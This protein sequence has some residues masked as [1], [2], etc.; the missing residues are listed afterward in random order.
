M[1]QLGRVLVCGAGNMAQGIFEGLHT[2]IDLSHYFFYTPSGHRAQELAKRVGA[3]WLK[4]LSG[5]GGFDWIFLA[6]KPQQLKDLAPHVKA[7]FPHTPVVSFLAALSEA[8][9]RQVLGAEKLIRLMPNLASRYHQGIALLCSESAPEKLPLV[10]E[11][12]S[13]LGYTQVVKENELDELTL[14]T[15]SGPAIFYELTHILAQSFHS[16]TPEV[17]Q[18][19]A[20]RTLQGAACITQQ[21][22]SALSELIDQVTSK[23]GVTMAL[24][25]KSRALGLKSVI[26]QAVNRGLERLKEMRAQNPS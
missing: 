12:F 8:Q 24:L 11:I 9:Q 15:G 26:Q 14:L 4:D 23:G 1:S 19:L 20:R 25:E 13:H 5:E 17:R 3:E 7:H 22:S 18:E 16:L 2:K 6:L 21:S 10:Q